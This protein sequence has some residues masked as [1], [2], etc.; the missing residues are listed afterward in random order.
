MDAVLAARSFFKMHEGLNWAAG[1]WRGPGWPVGE[2]VSFLHDGRNW[3]VVTE[4]Y[5]HLVAGK[6]EL[7]AV[8]LGHCVDRC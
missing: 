6:V 1:M 8:G 4:F 2:V 7:A 5:R 3:A